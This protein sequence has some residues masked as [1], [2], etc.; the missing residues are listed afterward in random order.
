V[1]RRPQATPTRVAIE[2]LIIALDAGRFDFTSVEDG[3][4]FDL[5]GDGVMER[6]AWTS[7]TSRNAFLALDVIRTGRIENGRKLF[8]GLYGA[9]NGFTT[10]A[11][12]EQEPAR[13]AAA[14]AIPERSGAP[15][16]AIDSA[17]PLYDQLILW[18]D[19]N[20]NGKAE[21]IELHSLASEGV[22]RIFVGAVGLGTRDRF[23]NVF[24]F[25]AQGLV[26]NR[27]GVPVATEVRSVRFANQ[28]LR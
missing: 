27:D 9:E 5:D 1:V 12:F 7:A 11:R 19:S 10:L 25:A 4:A 15:D 16:A 18:I 21:G 28:P 17:D 8:G 13:L 23:G 22:V 14:T 2:P 3:V 6:T 24:K 20:H 26:K